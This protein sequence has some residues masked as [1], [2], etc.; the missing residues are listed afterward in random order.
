VAAAQP[1]DRVML[2]AGIYLDDVVTINKP[3]TIEGAGSGAVLRITKPISN[4]KGILVV[5]ADLTVRKLTFE[6]AF[7]TDA[8]GRN[9][10]GIRHQAGRLVVDTCVFINNQ[11][12]ILANANRD[13][14]VAI[15]RSVFFGNGAGDGYTHGIYINAVAQ[16]TVSNSIFGGTKTGHNIKSRALKTTITDTVL[17]D[18]ITG[19]PSYAVDLPNGGEVVLKGLRITQGQRTTNTVMLAYGAEN[20]LHEN[21]SLTITGSTFI[22]QAQN[23][24]GIYNFSP[25]TATVSDTTFENVGVIAKGPVQMNNRS[26]LPLLEGGAVFSGADPNARSYFRFHNTGTAPASVSVHLRDGRDGRYLGTWRSPY[27]PPNAAPQYSITTLEAALGVENLPPTYTVAIETAMTGTFQHVLHRPNSGVL[28]SLSSCTRGVTRAGTAIGG[29]HTTNLQHD[30]PA[31][32]F[33]QNFGAMPASAD[34][35]MYDARTGERVAYVTSPEIPVDGDTLVPISVLEAFAGVTPAWDMAH[36]VLK[37]ENDFTGA[38]QHMIYNGA[39][40]IVTDLTAVCALNGSSAERPPAPSIGPV[41]PTSGSLESA[42]HIYNT[43]IVTAPFRVTIYD[44]PSGSRVG[45]WDSPPLAPRASRKFGVSTILAAA[46]AGPGFYRLSIESG[47]AGFIQHVLRHGTGASIA[48]NLT[49]CDGGTTASLRDAASLRS[50]AGEGDELGLMIL[51]NSGAVAAAASLDVFDAR[52]G[53]ALGSFTTAPVPPAGNVTLTVV[54]VETGLGLPANSGIAAFN[55][56]LANGFEG[57]M[58]H[59]SVSTRT[60]AVSDMTTA[61]AIGP[62]A[63]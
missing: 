57:T 22:N 30:Y 41:F 17:D 59:L 60:G 50:S 13:A 19:T 42:L 61:C 38:L 58:Q 40:G 37:I 12:G 15:R 32:V 25:I 45:Q 62:N 6:D 35:G 3:L 48:T 14:S 36:W 53:R 27:I 39:Q 21:S 8:D 63:G 18:G 56:R 11:N 2:D 1:N 51:Y 54:D 31:S 44:S 28:T 7:V 4:S 5:N 29:V 23:S 49:S 55:I 10:A 47:F 26:S 24:T 9:G 33:I 16:L 46:G 43:G 20:G 52:D 34:I